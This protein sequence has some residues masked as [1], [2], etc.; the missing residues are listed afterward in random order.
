MEKDSIYN[1]YDLSEDEMVYIFSF[2]DF[3]DIMKNLIY[4]S[5]DWLDYGATAIQQ[6]RISTSNPYA[7][8]DEIIL[9]ICFVIPSIES[10][11]LSCS[12]EISAKSLE[13]LSKYHHET[14][15][16][17]D[18]GYCYPERFENINFFF[19]ICKNLEC[20]SMNFMKIR[21]DV[22]E[23]ITKY[24]NGKI[25]ELRLEYAFCDDDSIFNLIKKNKN[26]EILD[27]TQIPIT[28][29]TLKE[30]SKLK[31]LKILILDEIKTFSKSDL[32]IEII[33]SCPDLTYFS[34]KET[35][36]LNFKIGSFLDSLPLE[37]RKKLNVEFA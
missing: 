17:I 27:L 26:L 12:T 35:R 11:D 7:T 13:Y 20:I 19:E 28:N 18:I 14:L 8:T 25:K 5:H 16:S 37:R 24:N 22:I 33:N 10:L 15:K 32:I 1:M 2:F 6:Q 29:K 4:V 9:A 30:I 36:K 34:L 21:N 3:S 31:N 23:T